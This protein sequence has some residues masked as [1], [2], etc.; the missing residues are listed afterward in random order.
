MN[1]Y[2]WIT[3]TCF[4]AAAEMNG[5]GIQFETG[6]WKDV[7][8][9]AK[10]E[11]KPIFVDAYT[12]WCAPC[13]KMS[14]DVFT[15]DPVGEYFNST[16]VN[17]KIDTEKGEGIEFA[18]QYE[19]NAFP[20]LL[21]FDSAGKLA[22]KA[23]GAKDEEGLLS[24]ARLSLNPEYQLATYKKEYE[25]GGKTI[26]DLNKYAMKLKESG[27]H[28]S[29]AE[30]VG[31]YFMNMKE[32]DRLTTD[33]WKLVSDYIYDYKTE[34]VEYVLKNKAKYY[35]LAGKEKL[36]RYIFNVLAI[37][38]IPGTR[39]ADSRETYYGTLKKYSRYVPVDY[40]VA[41]MQYFE[42][43]N[44]QPDSCFKYAKN[45]FDKKYAMIL[46]DDKLSYYRV[47][48]A[49]RYINE[50]NEKFEAAL[51]WAGQALKENPNDHKAAF[52]L[53]QL[54][55]KK[56]SCK[57]SLTWAEKARTGFGEKPE[58]PAVQKLFRIDTIEQF[59]KEVQDCVR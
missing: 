37:R 12:T 16:F 58:A 13:K 42:H 6:S 39:G 3:L 30:L 18:K 32:K 38:S 2:V 9:K 26:P 17:F 34:V 15:K 46:P 43:L 41:R 4:L 19:V 54:L 11:K 7:I 50:T 25:E 31:S 48:I 49:N 35:Q 23:V 28:A 52:V 24:Q 40:L 57:E 27:S 5:Q 36:N 1:K 33:G 20:T 51:Q 45:L 22:F 14:K 21:Y 55:F 29:A 47:F 59:V 53:A 56:G 10:A 44:G 8:A